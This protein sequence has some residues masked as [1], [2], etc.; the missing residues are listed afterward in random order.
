MSNL[1][2][3][4]LLEMNK[5]LSDEADELNKKIQ[6]NLLKIN[7]INEYLNRVYS[8]E[9]EEFKVFSPRNGGSIFKE[10]TDV[11]I[12]ER[13]TL[14][15]D[16]RDLYS[17]YNKINAYLDCLKEVTDERKDNTNSVVLDIQ[18]Q[19]R[20]RI[21]RDLH[22]T[23]LQNLS[24][25]VHKIELASMY[26]ERDKKQAQLELEIISKGIRDVIDE[27]RNTIFDLRPMH[28]DDLGFKD[29]FS[30][31]FDK[32]KERYPLFDFE[33]KISSISC[34]NNTILMTIYRVVQEACN[35]AAKHSNGNKVNVVIEEDNNYCN[36]V[37]EDN[38][39]GFQV[40]E[41]VKDKNRHYGLKILKERVLLLGGEIQFESIIN[42]GTKV[43]IKIPLV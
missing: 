13:N 37:I 9:D 40:D 34:N 12:S 20:Q 6:Y 35:N 19:E 17:K 10:N 33:T 8:Q 28:F 18:E 7:E 38:G 31:L 2:F 3:N 36:I 11:K 32:L 30:G 22:D 26:I 24:Y 27:M 5:K 25:L 42:K 4:S 16:N 43:K 15:S 29:T 41:V 14:E 1:K 21:A 39:C 23:S